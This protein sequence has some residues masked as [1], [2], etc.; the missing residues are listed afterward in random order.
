MPAGDYYI[1][2]ASAG[3]VL[4]HDQYAEEVLRAPVNYDCDTGLADQLALAGPLGN[5]QYYIG[6]GTQPAFGTIQLNVTQTPIP[7]PTSAVSLLAISGLLLKR[8]HR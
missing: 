7:E 8:K 1:A 3:L 5:F 6:A 4:A 2:V